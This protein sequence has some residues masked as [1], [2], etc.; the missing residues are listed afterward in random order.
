[1]GNNVMF[2]IAGYV[3]TMLRHFVVKALG[4]KTTIARLSKATTKNGDQSLVEFFGYG[5]IFNIV[6]FH[7]VI[8]SLCNAL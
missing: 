3:P 4:F 8:D 5:A 2:M 1:M 7:G 6:Y